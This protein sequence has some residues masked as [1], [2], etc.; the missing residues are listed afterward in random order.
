MSLQNTNLNLES[1]VARLEQNITLN[2]KS[3]EFLKTEMRHKL[4]ELKMTESKPMVSMLALYYQNNV[5]S[6]I[7]EQITAFV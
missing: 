6:W 1:E 5:N 4:E 2:V 3:M 7:F